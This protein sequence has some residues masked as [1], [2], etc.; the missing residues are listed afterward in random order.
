MPNT[1]WLCIAFILDDI[2][3]P[4][5]LDELPLFHQ[6]VSCV[7]ESPFYADCQNY[8]D[9][10]LTWRSNKDRLQV[11]CNL[12]KA[13]ATADDPRFGWILF[14]VGPAFF[15]IILWMV[16]HRTRARSLEGANHAQ[17]AISHSPHL[18]AETLVPVVSTRAVQL[19]DTDSVKCLMD[20]RY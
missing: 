15:I 14:T 11:I 1:G 5:L 9:V 12:T 6:T 18:S 17:T 2:Y 10:G 7:G 4:R 20:W 13:S 16:E 19:H 3:K 8:G